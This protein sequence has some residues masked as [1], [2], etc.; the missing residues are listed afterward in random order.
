MDPKTKAIFDFYSKENKSDFFNAYLYMKYLYQFEL[1][2]MTS[3][4]LPVN[5][6]IE[7]IAPS[8]EDMLQAY[9]SIVREAAGNPE[10]D[11]YHAK[12]VQPADA[13]KLVSL[14]V[15]LHIEVPETVVPFKLA[16]DILLKQTDS[17]A[18]GACP[19]R[20][21]QAECTCMPPPLEACLFIGDPHAS[22]MAEH[23]PRFRKVSRDEAAHIL[24]DCHERGFVHCAYFKKDMGNRLFAICNCCSCCCGGIK[25]HNLLSA[26]G[27]TGSH[28]APSGYVAAVGEACTGCQGCIDSCQFHAISLSDTGERA[29]IDFD[30]CM[31]CGVCEDRCPGEAIKLR[32]EP[33]KGGILDLDELRK[34]SG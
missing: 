9:M 6:A 5:P 17:F 3:L 11:V 23:N 2:F 31:G 27:R 34:Y 19:C 12:V 16:R 8:L 1:L 30:K 14:D 32:V 24:A 10:T 21:A 18:V 22:F 7:K 13:Q 28:V 15:D 20:L 25:V 29:F 33:S 26:K 4:R